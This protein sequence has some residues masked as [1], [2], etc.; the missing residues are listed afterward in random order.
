[1]DET[2]PDWM[3][4]GIVDRGVEQGITWITSRMEKGH[5]NGYVYLPEGHPYRGRRPSSIRSVSAPHGISYDDDEGWFGFD[6]N[7]GNDYWPGHP[8]SLPADIDYPGGLIYWTPE[9]VAEETRK[10][11]RQVA[12]RSGSST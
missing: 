12:A 4:E 3:R 6:T 2:M 7:H 9:M 11:A 1:M 8:D 5:I 10:L